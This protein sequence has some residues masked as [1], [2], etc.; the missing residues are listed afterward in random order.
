MRNM[1]KSRRKKLEIESFL[2]EAKSE[3]SVQILNLLKNIVFIK[4]IHIYF[5]KD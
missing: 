1:R 3:I 2:I 5:A 4:Y